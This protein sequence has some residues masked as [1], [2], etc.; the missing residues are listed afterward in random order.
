VALSADAKTLVIGAPGLD[1]EGYVK[2]Y[3]MTDDGV[4]RTQLGQTIYGNAT[5][6]RFGYSA[7]VTAQG[8]VIILSS[9]R[10]SGY[11][12]RQGYVQ[13]FS[14]DSDDET[15]GTTGTWKQVGQDIAGEA[16]MDEFGYSVSISDDGKTIAVGAPYNDGKNGEDSGHF[17]IYRLADDGA[18]WKQIGGDIDGDAADDYSGTSVSLSANGTI[19][20]IG[21]PLGCIYSTGQV[22]VYRIDSGGLSWEQL[23]QSIYGDNMNDWFGASVDISP[24]GNCLAVGTNVFDGPGYVKV[25][26][27]ENGDG[28][29]DDLGASSWKKIGLTITGDA[30][31]DGFGWSVSLSDDA[32][33]LAVG[34]P[35]ANSKSGRVR[36]YRTDDSESGWTKIGEDIEGTAADDESGLPVSLSGDGKTVA[37][38]SH[39]NDDNGTDSGHVRVFVVTTSLWEQQG[40]AIVGDAAGDSLGTSVALSADAKTLVIGAPY[41]NDY[42]GY[43]KV[44]Q[45]TDDGVNRT[46]LG[47][48]IYG[49]STGD[50]FGYSVDVTAQGNVIVLSSP[51][52]N[53][54]P[55]Y[56]QVFSLDSDNETAG[57]TGTWKQ[58]GKVIAGESYFIS[59]G[60]SV[61]IS[62]D[63]KKITVGADTNDGKNGEDSSHVWI[64]RL[65]SDGASW[66]KIGGDL[67][68][69]PDDYYS[70]SSGS[71]VSLSAILCVVG[72]VVLA[73]TIW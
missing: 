43:V 49:N 39:L 62:D 67:L 40:S 45:M 52:Y 26:S 50:R 35:Y 69:A 23:G 64:Y 33:T 11:N 25:F 44:Y 1:R 31:G 37:I 59:F 36:V 56:V 19:V 38:G 27:L 34:A 14:L 47:Q 22:K 18:S 17:R 68:S 61:S 10:Y 55:G 3:R 53:D 60:Y 54:K 58:V 13:V 51:S 8:N 9:P 15:A 30:N 29:D 63:G 12:N 32:K 5:G 48:T 41:S 4:N 46:Q 71:S 70:V 72:M 28:D 16:I 65:S 73:S 66:E 20:A 21:A 2:V 7:D 24:D 57:T 6:D 42:T